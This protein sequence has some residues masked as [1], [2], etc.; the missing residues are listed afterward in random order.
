M[1][2]ITRNYFQI[3]GYFTLFPFNVRNDVML[4]YCLS[5]K[6]IIPEKNFDFSEK[7]H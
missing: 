7:I 6:C 2:E 3:C 4:A 1:T 5:L